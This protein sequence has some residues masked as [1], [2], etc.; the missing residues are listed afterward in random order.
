MQSAAQVHRIWV[1][2]ARTIVIN[3]LVESECRVK[4]HEEAVKD[5]RETRRRK[6]VDAS[7]DGE[8]NREVEQL[9][10][11]FIHYLLL[12]LSVGENSLY[13]II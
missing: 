2:N 12:A 7:S 8:S 1:I 13:I 5:K 3:C 9:L 6:L 10:I 11:Y 4:W